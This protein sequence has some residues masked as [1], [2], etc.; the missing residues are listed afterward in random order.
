MVDVY[1]RAAHAVGAFAR[2]RPGQADRIAHGRAEAR[3]SDAAGQMSRRRGE[4]VATVERLAH[5]RAPIF[6]RGQFERPPLGVREHRRE[7]AVVGPDEELTASGHDD[8]ATIRP[9]TGVDHRQV[10][11]T[12]GEGRRRRLQGERGFGHLLGLDVVGD[13]HQMD[14]GHACA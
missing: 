3:G 10:D 13:V 2:F 14:I 11:R 1:H 7:Q 4:D 8:R 6:A 9:Y 5:H 12:G